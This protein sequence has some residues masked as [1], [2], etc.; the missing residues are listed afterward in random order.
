VHSDHVSSLRGSPGGWHGRNTSLY[1]PMWYI[2]HS[3]APS[4]TAGQVLTSRQSLGVPNRSARGRV[5]RFAPV[6]RLLYPYSPLCS[7][8]ATT[9]VV[10]YCDQNLS[11]CGGCNVDLQPHPSC[12]RST[13]TY[14]R[15]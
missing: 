10:F 12:W 2:G 8:S 5:V 3:L 9:P 6:V 14:V 13:I 4:L 11:R 15:P 1:D 7:C